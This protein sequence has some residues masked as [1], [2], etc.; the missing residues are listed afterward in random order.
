MPGSL[1]RSAAST[2]A[3]RTADVAA[4][5]GD[6][7]HERRREVRV[8]LVR[9]EEDR[10]ELRPQ[11]PVHERHLELVLEVG[12]GAQPADDDAAFSALAKSTSRP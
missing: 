4:Q 9:R 10:L 8:V 3:R 12:D 2:A 1:R 11:V 5:R 7:A 6:L